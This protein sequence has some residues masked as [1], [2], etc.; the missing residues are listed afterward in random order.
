MLAKV[1][2]LPTAGKLLAKEK[3]KGIFMRIWNQGRAL[4]FGCAVL[5]CLHAGVQGMGV[6]CGGILRSLDGL[7]RAM[8]LGPVHYTGSGFADLFTSKFCTGYLIWSLILESYQRTDPR[9]CFNIVVL[10]FH[11]LL[12]VNEPPAIFHVHGAFSAAKAA[13]G[14]VLFAKEGAIRAIFSGPVISNNKLSAGLVAAK[15]AVEIFI[16]AGWANRCP[17]M[18]VSDRKVFG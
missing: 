1:S 12:S 16:S 9:G 11:T 6:G 4:S 2:L 13:C 18:L 3:T 17:L 8:V 15:T 7:V 10:G 14:G 5:G